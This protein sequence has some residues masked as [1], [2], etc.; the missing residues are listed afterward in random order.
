MEVLPTALNRHLPQS[1][2][3][4]SWICV[5]FQLPGA[6]VQFPP[7][8]GLGAPSCILAGSTPGMLRGWLRF[9]SSRARDILS[10]ALPPRFLCDFKDQTKPSHPG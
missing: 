6:A 5:L 1:N 10:T 2:P 4:P 9:P 7:K 3:N 8:V